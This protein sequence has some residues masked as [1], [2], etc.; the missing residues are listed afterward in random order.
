MLLKDIWNNK[1]SFK[2]SKYSLLLK[3]WSMQ[4]EI[5]FNY[6]LLI[7]FGLVNFL[8]RTHLAV[9]AHHCKTCNRSFIEKSHLVR[10]ERIHLED[11]PFK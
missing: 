2:V 1:Q 7:I 5:L 10:H 8:S 3:E 4:S 11:K 9:R 6:F